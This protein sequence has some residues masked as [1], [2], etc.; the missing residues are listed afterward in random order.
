MARQVY[1]RPIGFA[2]SPQSELGEAIRLGGSMVWASRFALIVRENGVV[3]RRERVDVPAMPTALAGLPDDLAQEA[4][5]QWAN[6]RKSHPALQCGNRTIRFDQPQVMAI[7]NRTP[8]SFSD[9]GRFDS[10]L[11]AAADHAMQML[12]AGAAIIDV[13]GESTRP[14]A[15]SVWEGDEIARVVPIVDRLAKAGAA[16]SVDTRRAGVMEAALKV[17]AHIFNDVSGLRFDPRSAELAANAG[18]PVVLMHAP[19]DGND[20]HAEHGYRD[21][22]LDVFDRLRALRDR[23]VEQGI[24]PERIWLD[25]GIGFGMSVAENLALMNCLALFHALG[26][27][28]LLGA[29]RKR[30]IGALAGEVPADQRLGGSL[31]LALKA[32]EAGCHVI[33][34]HDAMETV[35]ALRVW[36][37]LR[38]S[39]LTDF[40][41][42]P[43]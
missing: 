28:I 31:T 15:A 16:I 22:V 39:A 33:R 11:D 20:L 27:P 26:H 30:L 5:A 41:Q 32:A 10:D 38:D 1:I 25:P 14:G 24:A 3:T 2:E 21:V 8:D 40:S 23:A 42:I 18:T 13:G 34:V 17:G 19:G 9:G 12:E 6:L 4:E 37:G 7:L 35:Q 43:E 29:S 36:R